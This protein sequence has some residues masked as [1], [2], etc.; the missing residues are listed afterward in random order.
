MDRDDMAM[1][2]ITYKEKAREYVLAARALGASHARIIFRHILPNTVA[3]IVLSPL[4][5]F[6]AA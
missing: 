6:Q 5:R 3:I 4:F 1:R 2:T